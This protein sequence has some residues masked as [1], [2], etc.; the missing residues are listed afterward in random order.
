MAV[1]FGFAAECFAAGDLCAC[2]ER[3]RIVL[4]PR[5]QNDIDVTTHP[6]RPVFFKTLALY[7]TAVSKFLQVGVAGGLPGVEVDEATP[8]C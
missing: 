4:R 7:F 2:Y 3:I 8:L 5:W 1:P 6:H